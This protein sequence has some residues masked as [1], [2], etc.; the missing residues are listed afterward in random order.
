MKRSPEY[1]ALYD[2]E[3]EE[4]RKEVK[5]AVEYRLSRSFRNPDVETTDSG[6]TVAM[7]KATKLLSSRRPSSNG[8]ANDKFEI[9]PL[10][11]FTNLFSSAFKASS[12]TYDRSL[13]YIRGVEGKGR[14]VT[15][16][17]KE[18][19]GGIAKA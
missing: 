1:R 15:A 7:S 14:D 13:R 11:N 3:K 19:S 12:N 10:I 4:D 6:I 8:N 16:S 17:N 9:L 2:A 18:R 5:A